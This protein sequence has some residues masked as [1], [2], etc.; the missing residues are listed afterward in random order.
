MPEHDWPELPYE[1][2][3]DT[4]ATLHMK[5]QIVGKLRL[6]LSPFEPEW[7][8]VALY[9]TPRGLTTGPMSS[10]GLIFGVDADLIAHQVVITTAAG[11][12][13][14]VAL[15]ASPVATFYKDFTAALDGLGIHAK[16]RPVPDEVSDP[17]P[18]AEDTVHSTYD[19]EWANRFFHVLARADLVLKEHRSRFR[20][21]TSPVHF[22]WGS[23]DLANTRYSGRTAEPP[24]G[25]DV[26][27]R[28]SEDAEQICAGFWP[29]NAAFP[30]P[31]ADDG[32]SRGHERFGQRNRHLAT[33]ALVPP[34][35]SRV[36]RPRGAG[37]PH[38]VSAGNCNLGDIQQ[39]AAGHDLHV[40]RY[41]H[42]RRWQGQ[43]DL[44]CSH[45]RT[46][47]CRRIECL[48]NL[49]PIGWQHGADPQRCDGLSHAAL[50]IRVVVAWV[51]CVD[52]GAAL[53]ECSGLLLAHHRSFVRDVFD[54]AHG[55]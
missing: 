38:H 10:G 42:R 41:R 2:W 51:G 26:I 11:A 43:P 36:H 53:L 40:H 24:P 31:A 25:A 37:R 8:H 33:R 45:T 46:L 54:Q 50:R 19:P 1:A 21:R 18:F 28:K 49:A 6:A 35:D 20:G 3:K 29:G 9:L 14:Q 52:I 48:A 55:P 44:E 7:A 17:I 47:Q 12:T 27:A 30:E 23:F 39:L 16:I 15:V 32:R 13:R 22:F 5:L 34:A 4:L